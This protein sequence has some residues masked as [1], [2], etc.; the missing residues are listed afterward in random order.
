MSLSQA[1]FSPW[2][3]YFLAYDPTESWKQVSCPVLAI[4]G[5]KDI[6]VD[7]ATNLH[8]IESNLKIGGNTR[9]EIRLLD[10][11][12]HLMQPCHV[13]NLGEY[14]TIETTMDV[15]VLEIVRNFILSL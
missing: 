5:D 9:S 8:A 10:G 13:C 14:A 6:Q 1:F 4:N 15:Q 3:R 7:G 2:F 11:L 12:N